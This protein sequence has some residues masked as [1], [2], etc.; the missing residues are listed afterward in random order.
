[1]LGAILTIAK[2]NAKDLG[3]VKL[4]LLELLLD[5]EQEHPDQE[6]DCGPFLVGE[7]GLSEVAAIDLVTSLDDW[8]LVKEQITGGRTAAALDADGREAVRRIRA[9]RGDPAVRAAVA[10]DAL[11]KFLYQVEQGR[12]GM[13]AD[14]VEVVSSDLGEFLGSRLTKDEVVREVAYLARKGLVEVLVVK[15]SGQPASVRLTDLGRDCV[16]QFGGDV[17]EFLQEREGGRT[18]YNT[19]IDSISGGNGIAVGG[20]VTQ[21]VTVGVDAAGLRELVASVLPMLNRLG[22]VDSVAAVALD[23]LAVQAQVERP[24]PGRVRQALGQVLD[25]AKQVGAGALVVYLEYK[26]REWGFMPDSSPVS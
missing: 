25:V 26:A 19:K 11:V 24:E 12:P 2:I 9:H 20:Q 22:G 18:V 23:E 3:P 4:G 13:P 5:Y 14:P 21:H 8:G 15:A 17:A 7:C 10:R 16:D 6:M 1:M